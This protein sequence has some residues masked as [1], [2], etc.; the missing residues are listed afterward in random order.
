MPM[1]TSPGVP[2]YIVHAVRLSADILSVQRRSSSVYTAQ[3][4]TA[5]SSSISPVP[6]PSSIEPPRPRITTT[7]PTV[8]TSTAMRCIRVTGSIPSSPAVSVTSAGMPARISELLVADVRC[9]P[10]MKQTW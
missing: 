2:V 7:T 9:S 4:N 6:K 3:V 5:P 10:S 1:S 8:A